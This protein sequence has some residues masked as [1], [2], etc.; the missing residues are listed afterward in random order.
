MEKLA[1]TEVNVIVELGLLDHVLA[2]ALSKE[3]GQRF[4]SAS[5]FAQ[6]ALAAVKGEA[7][8]RQERYVGVGDAA[9]AAPTTQMPTLV[10]HESRRRGR[11]RAIAA[12]AVVLVLAATA[13]ALILAGGEDAS[14]G[15]ETTARALAEDDGPS[16][17]ARA[18]SGSERPAN[19]GKPADDERQ[20]AQGLT[21]ASPISTEGIG[22]VLVGMQESEAEVEG[23]MTLTFET[24]GYDPCQYA[25][26]STL[27]DVGF[28]FVEGVLARI[29]VRNPDV[30]T[31]SG[32]TVG[33]GVDDVLSA[34]PGQIIEEPNF[35]DPKAT[36]LT[37]TPE[38][39]K[40]KTRVIFEADPDGAVTNIRAGRL[41]EVEYVEGRA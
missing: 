12:A 29:D 41:P 5:D 2:R 37:Y 39:P 20:G 22:P 9:A 15:A 32:I 1:G 6:S 16:A 33:D 31:L 13:G 30:A 8:T 34:Y 26:T 40:D 27:N 7:V 35:Y 38:D 18:S 25:Q 36:N 3:P 21:V 14:D 28:M 19:Q 4:P 17:P 24:F 10:E 11:Y 23:R